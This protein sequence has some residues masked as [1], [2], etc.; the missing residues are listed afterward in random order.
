MED[1]LTREE[2]LSEIKSM[3]AEANTAHDEFEA[4]ATMAGDKRTLEVYLN[5]AYIPS[6]VD[7][8]GD[9]QAM[10]ALKAFLCGW[11]A[12]ERMKGRFSE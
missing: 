9:E 12:H 3:I 8:F 11:V 1:A 6:L 10:F 7:G 2:W 4:G 5:R